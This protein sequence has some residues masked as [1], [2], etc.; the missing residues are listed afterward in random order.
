MVVIMTKRNIA[1]TFKEIPERYRD[2]FYHIIFNLFENSILGQF[3]INHNIKK[4]SKQNSNHSVIITL[5][6]SENVLKMS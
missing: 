4:Q 3:K 1:L 2:F 5:S 6:K